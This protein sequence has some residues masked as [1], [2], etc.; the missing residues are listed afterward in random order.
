ME[1]NPIFFRLSLSQPEKVRE[2]QVSSVFQDIEVKTK[3]PQGGKLAA[4]YLPTS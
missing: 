4:V 1:V 2:R 3:I